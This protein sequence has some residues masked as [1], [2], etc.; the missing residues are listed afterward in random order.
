MK[1]LFTILL[2]PFLFHLLSPRA[3][4]ASTIK[5]AIVDLGI[6]DMEKKDSVAFTKLIRDNF[7]KINH[8][9][10]VPYDKVEEVFKRRDILSKQKLEQYECTFVPCAVKVGRATKADYAVIGRLIKK[11]ETNDK[12]IV[13]NI[14]II[15]LVS[16]RVEYSLNH[17]FMNKEEFAVNASD[18][19]KRL[20]MW[21]HQDG[22]TKQAINKRRSE[23]EKLV[24]E[25]Y[26]VFWKRNRENAVFKHKPGECP[27]GMALI[28]AGKFKSGSLKSDSD[29]YD[30]EAEN[31]EVYLDEY[32]IDIYE[33]PNKKGAKP[34]VKQEWFGG[35]D[36]CEKAGKS[37]CSEKQW[38]KA[39][40][41]P[42][43]TAYT[44]GDTFDQDKCNTAYIKNGKTMFDRKTKRAGAYGECKNGYGVYD[45]SGNVYEWTNDSYEGE[46]YYRVIRGGSWFD[47]KTK[48]SRCATR[49][50]E[51]PFI[52]DMTI[53]FRCCLE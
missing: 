2:L 13:A 14:Q 53:G 4:H 8:Y 44:Y 18:M 17:S 36:S 28:P 23:L 35:K 30:D 39:C 1:K 50:S 46:F 42:S 47:Q 26:R 41:G 6:T 33:F 7:A 16:R 27:P 40:K 51:E 34:L 22:E 3:S 45:M 37:L 10:V 29:R 5:L 9:S 38:E 21:F 19:V 49:N 20:N 32:C 11:N 43:G 12:G 15:G 25:D 31:K 24:E 48:N 52:H